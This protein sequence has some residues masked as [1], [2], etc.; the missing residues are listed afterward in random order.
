MSEKKKRKDRI[1]T[2]NGQTC[3]QEE[4]FSSLCMNFLCLLPLVFL[5]LE[6]SYSTATISNR[7]DSIWSSF[8]FY[9]VDFKIPFVKIFFFFTA[10]LE[11]FCS[12]LQLFIFLFMGHFFGFVFLSCVVFAVTCP[13]W[14]LK[15]INFPEMQFWEGCT[16]ERIWEGLYYCVYSYLSLLI[17]N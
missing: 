11:W 3:R 2:L 14:G 10:G 15:Q 17:S 9:S 12:A 16:R 13:E 6:T 5:S 4:V 8:L 1:L 7:E